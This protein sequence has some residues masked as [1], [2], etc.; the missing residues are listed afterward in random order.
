MSKTRLLCAIVGSVLLAVSACSSTPSDDAVQ[1]AIERRTQAAPPT[2]LNNR[3]PL[4][5]P[6][7]TPTPKPRVSCPDEEVMSYL[8]ELQLL[9]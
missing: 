2:S 3:L 4:L 1:T 6:S 8:E 5:D 7:P 9:L